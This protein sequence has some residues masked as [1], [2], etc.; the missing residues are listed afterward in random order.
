MDSGGGNLADVIQ[1][2]TGSGQFDY[3]FVEYGKYTIEMTGMVSDVYGNEYEGGGTYDLYVAEPLDIEPATLP[4]T[5]FEVGDF[6][7]PGITVL[8][9]VPAKVEVKVSL[10][11]ES[12]PEQTVGYLVEGRANRFGTFTP[13]L[14]SRPIMMTGP[15][16]LVV[17]TTAS[18][19]DE[20]GVLWM[21]SSRWGQVVETP[22]SPVIAH[23]R[24]GRDFDENFEPF[25]EVKVWFNDP[26]PGDGSHA[27]FSY[28]SGDILWQT[29]DDAGKVKISMQDRE[30]LVTA[31]MRDWG[32][33]GHLNVLDERSR[34]DE[35]LLNSITE[36]RISPSLAPD[37]IFV[38]GYW[39]GS[40][41]RPGERVRE[42]LSEDMLDQH[43]STYWR[44]QEV[45][46][47]QP[48]IGVEGDLPNDFKFLFGGTVFRDPSRGLNRYAI[49]GGLWVALP[50]DGPGTRVFPP[51]Q[52][53][54]G[55]PSG[56]PIMTIA[57][58]EIDAF[59]V[60]LA[61]RPG[62][63]LETGDT[64]SFSAHLAPTLPAKLDVIVTGPAVSPRESADGRIPL[65]TSMILTRTFK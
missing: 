42:I 1:L 26:F 31:A 25:P 60:P 4:M 5:P 28:M 40:V 30:G 15:G 37:D 56:G 59:V 27:Q 48:G 53:A 46:A 33:P 63:I 51:F 50:T 44:F 61:V 19:T 29:D 65:V 24:R 16:E 10:M 47:L 20:K 7:N 3:R 22:G 64:F 36:S 35:L 2:S 11:V 55:G 14:N 9:G 62:T 41:Q 23:G 52:G 43:G 34:I 57:A 6:L 54:N 12:D 49:Y 17:D 58:E 45:Y 39:Y 38:H 13:D 18:Y 21:G 32:P 8:P